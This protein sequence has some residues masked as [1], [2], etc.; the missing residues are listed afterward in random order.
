[1]SEQSFEDFWTK[2]YSVLKNVEVKKMTFINT[3]VMNYSLN[4]YVK[5][6]YYIF[7]SIT[8][9]CVIRM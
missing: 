8:C 4:F 1:M 3:Y 9:C 7:W 5:C 6:S 2:F